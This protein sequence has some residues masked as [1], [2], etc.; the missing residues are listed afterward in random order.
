VAPFTPGGG[1][2]ATNIAKVEPRPVV[3]RPSSSAPASSRPDG[4]REIAGG[5]QGIHGEKARKERGVGVASARE[6][7][8]TISP[9]KKNFLTVKRLVVR[10]GDGRRE[11][12]YL[13]QAGLLE[14]AP[15]R[16]RPAVARNQE[17]V[18]SLLLLLSEPHDLRRGVERRQ[19]RAP[20]QRDRAGKLLLD[21]ARERGHEVGAVDHEEGAAGRRGVDVGVVFGDLAHYHPWRLWRRRQG[22]RSGR[23]GRG[24]G[25]R[26]GG[27]RRRRHRRAG[28]DG[29]RDQPPGTHN[30]PGFDAAGDEGAQGALGADHHAVAAFFFR[31]F[32]WGGGEEKKEVRNLSVSSLSPSS[33]FSLSIF[34]F[35]SLHL[36]FSLSPSLSLS[37]FLSLRVLFLEIKRR[38][39]RELTFC[40]RRCHRLLRAGAASRRVLPSRAADRGRWPGR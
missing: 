13:D 16:R 27:R 17:V 25:S 31:F 10:E 35:L 4:E 34:S 21:V 28:E 37:R 1:G 6:K 3:S 8:Q 32:F 39:K 19:R 7:A 5:G 12:R 40:A 9:Q 14:R 20:V 38:L 2:G 11:L 15:R 18:A 30:L 29:R 24:G 23:S 22:G 33:L 36:L 26:G